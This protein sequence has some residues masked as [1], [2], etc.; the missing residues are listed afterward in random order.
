MCNCTAGHYSQR[1]ILKRKI[2]T[3]KYKSRP[4]YSRVKFACIQGKEE[5]YIRINLKKNNTN[6]KTR[7]NLFL[8]IYQEILLGSFDLCVCVLF[9]LS[10][11]N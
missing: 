7:Y 6:V 3:E 11:K 10:N 2:R 9:L 4:E 8:Q 1:T 5:I